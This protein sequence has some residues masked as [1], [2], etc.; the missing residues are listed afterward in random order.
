MFVSEAGGLRFKSRVCQ[1]RHS[2]A[3]AHHR[4][5][6]CWKEV[7]LPAAGAMTRSWALPTRY[8]LWSDTAS[9]MKDLV[10]LQV[11]LIIIDIDY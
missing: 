10:N 3:T 4:S 6:I 2:A 8:T 11:T 9:I 1:I 5:D 7:V